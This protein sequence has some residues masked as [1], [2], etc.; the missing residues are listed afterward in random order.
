M[1]S[2]TKRRYINIVMKNRARVLFGLYPFSTS[3]PPLELGEDFGNWFIEEFEQCSARAE[4]TR[5][6]L[7][8]HANLLD[9]SDLPLHLREEW[10]DAQ[11]E[12]NIVDL[13]CRQNNNTDLPPLFTLGFQWRPDLRP[14]EKSISP[15][16]QASS[17]TNADNENSRERIEEAGGS[18]SHS[19]IEQLHGGSSN[20]GENRSNILVT[21][22]D[23][24][25]A[26]KDIDSNAED[27]ITVKLNR[28]SSPDM[29]GDKFYDNEDGAAENPEMP[30][31]S[32]THLEI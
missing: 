21:H 7:G 25:S 32:D 2:D 26:S 11:P 12:F 16:K 28:G 10:D 29:N 24:V 18:P 27:E 15:Q 14:T 22:D 9:G 3:P 6:E 20:N 19:N 31:G 23:T 1:A 13:I 4:K 17:S 5:C 30:L 8:S